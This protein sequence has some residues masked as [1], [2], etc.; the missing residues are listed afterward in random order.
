MEARKT[1]AA[2]IWRDFG[3]PVE[4]DGA[5]LSDPGG[6][7]GEAFTAMFYTIA[8]S[9]CAAARSDEIAKSDALRADDAYGA[10]AVRS[11]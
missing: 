4:Q 6:V 10:T 11:H 5:A 8:S 2:A 7:R 1:P 9:G 3:A